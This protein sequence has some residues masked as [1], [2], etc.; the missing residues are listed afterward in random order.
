MH[1]F[2][3]EEWTSHEFTLIELLVVIAII[4]ILAAM[5]LPALQGARE[6][7]SGT[8]CV[9][10]MKQLG[11][12][13]QLYGNDSNGYFWH[14]YGTFSASYDM[15]GY[16]RIAQ[17]IGGKSYSDV[18]ADSTYRKSESM[19]PVFM[20]P[21]SLQDFR[22]NSAVGDFWD[23]AAYP[24]TYNPNNAT[25]AANQI[26]LFRGTKF[27]VFDADEYVAPS[28]AVISADGY[29]SKIAGA[30]D[31]SA[32][33]LYRRVTGCYALP[34]ERHNGAANMLAA[35][36]HVQTGKV[37]DFQ[38]G[39]SRFLYVMD[40]GGEKKVVRALSFETYFDR[41]RSAQSVQ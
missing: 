24:L 1:I 13:I 23:L 36:G 31:A 17:Y 29:T 35:D 7:A 41:K 11:N 28:R 18:A 38:S 6:R 8:S 34:Y 26:G 25:P 10:N 5:L 20:C 14:R 33:C 37:Q 22:D 3:R 12:A 32:V 9:S 4:A 39:G 40:E 30:L 19:P 27:K 15:S 21:K 2:R 16:T